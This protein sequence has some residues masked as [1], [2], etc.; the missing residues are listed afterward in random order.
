MEDVL[1]R[2]SDEGNISVF[3]P[4]DTFMA[5]FRDGKWVNDLL[6]N[7][8]ELEEFTI[9]EDSNEILHILEQARAAL[10][11]PLKEELSADRAKSV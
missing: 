1:I 5:S 3:D 9:V 11:Q 8:Y 7:A 10:T 6:F 2:V 4:R